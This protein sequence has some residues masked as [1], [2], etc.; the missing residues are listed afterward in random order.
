[1]VERNLVWQDGN[2]SREER[3]QRGGT[4][5]CTVWFTGL[6]ASGKSTLASAL[7]RVLIDNGQRAYRLDG[8]NIRHGL[9]SDLG[10]SAADRAENIR[11]IGEVARLFADSGCV[12]LTAFISPY[13]ADRGRCRGLHERDG[14]LFLEVF[15]DASLAICEKRDPKGM[16]KKARAGQIEGFTGVDDP[17]EPPPHPDLVL[18]T[19]VL[20][21]AACIEACLGLLRRHQVIT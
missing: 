3:W 19:G 15:L 5:G 12:V 20:D 13:I 9:N 1:M 14:L 11:R 6:S 4:P 7:E 21:V 16:Y 2:I 17:Y 8:D 18:D 10:F